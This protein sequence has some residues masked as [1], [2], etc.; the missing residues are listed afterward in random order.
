LDEELNPRDPRVLA[1]TQP[2][3]AFDC[4]KHVE[5]LHHTADHAELELTLDQGKHRQIRRL[6]RASGCGSC[7]CIGAPSARSC[8]T[9]YLLEMF[10]LT[11]T[12]VSA[13]WMAVGGRE[14]IRDG[15]IAALA[16]H[17]RQ[18][19]HESRPDVRL[20]AWLE[21]EAATRPSLA[22]MASEGIRV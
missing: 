6:C 7:T 11:E 17:A 2:N 12:E 16:R 18:A 4:A 13:L 8:S 19:R 1:M 15:Q 21:S 9:I 14:R 22:N 10:A 5:L 20:E 3:P